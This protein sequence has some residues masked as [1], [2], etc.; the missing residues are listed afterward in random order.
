MSE[1]SNSKSGKRVGVQI[2]LSAPDFGRTFRQERRFAKLSQAQVAA[3]IGVTRQTVADIESGENVGLQTV[4]RALAALRRAV[5]IRPPTLRY[6]EEEEEE[7][8]PLDDEDD[9][10]D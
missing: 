7:V 5:E 3:K 6:N 4:F 10:D 8:V 9:R 2:I 1:K